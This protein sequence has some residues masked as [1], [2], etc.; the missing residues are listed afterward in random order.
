MS[1]SDVREKGLDKFEEV[2]GFRPPNIEGDAFLD[3]T[4]DHLFANVWSGPGLSV[5]DRRLVTLAI[6][7]CFG[8]EA[9]LRIHLNATMKQEQLS[10]VE[11]DELLVHMAHY[12][13]WPVAAV[14][15][16]IV[17]QLRHERDKAEA[18]A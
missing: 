11:I 1:N 7:M 15:S 3:V 12:G 4:I 18:N 5:R 17:R 14:S 6:L 16:Q 9:T 13:G 8:N 10:D 2:M